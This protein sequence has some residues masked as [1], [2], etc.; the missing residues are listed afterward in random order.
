[1]IPAT[2][3]AIFYKYN[4][5][6]VVSHTLQ[7][8]GKLY[9]AQYYGYQHQANANPDNFWNENMHCWTS[10]PYCALDAAPK[11]PWEDLKDPAKNLFKFQRNAVE[12]IGVKANGWRGF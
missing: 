10:D 7:P 9:R 11:R 2:L 4:Y 6:G 1:M 8:S 3:F 5:L 12:N